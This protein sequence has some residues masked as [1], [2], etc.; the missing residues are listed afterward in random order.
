MLPIKQQLDNDDHYKDQNKIE[1]IVIHDTGN[2]TDS[3]EAN[4]NYFTTGTR[5]ASAHYFVDDDSITQV[6]E[7]CDGA[8]HVG[9]GRNK[10]GIN[11]RNSLG[12]EMCR[13]SNKVSPRTLQNTIDLV[14]S[15]MVKYS[16]ELEKIVRHFDASRKNCPSSMSDNNW[17]KWYDFKKKLASIVVPTAPKTKVN[18]CLEWQKWYNE[19]T[20]TTTPLTCDGSYGK[21]TQ[22]S[23]NAL[24]G[25]IQQGK[26]YKYC[27]EFQKFYNSITQTKAPLMEDG[28]WGTNT[29]KAIEIINNIIK[30]NI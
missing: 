5:N 26:K 15:L 17:E 8:Y 9:D 14:K 24:I 12:I 20:K 27:L 10:Y 19:K 22:D 21:L 6:V 11:N 23:I 29:T 30:K 25:Y 7:D 13:T 1:Y 18:Y 28:C 16:I 4:A 2:S 3:D